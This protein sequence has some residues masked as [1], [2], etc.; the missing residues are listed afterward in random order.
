MDND[1]CIVI[2]FLIFDIKKK[3]KGKRILILFMYYWIYFVEDFDGLDKRVMIVDCRFY[4]AFMVN[5]L[6]GGGVECVG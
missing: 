2:F 6:K 4:R 5:R 1:I 3:G